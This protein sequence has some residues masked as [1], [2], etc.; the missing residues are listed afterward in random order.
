MNA[1]SPTRAG[2]DHDG[3]ARKRSD[4]AGVD[5]AGAPAHLRRGRTPQVIALASATDLLAP[6][7][8]TDA[9][10]VRAAIAAGSGAAAAGDG[11]AAQVAAPEWIELI[12]AGLFFGRDGRGPYRFDEPGAVIAATEALR[13][14]AGIPI[15]YDHATDFAAPEGRPA[16]AAGW[17]RELKVRSGALWGRVEWTD[18]AARAISEREYRYISPVFQYSRENGNVTRLLRAGLTNNPNLYLTAICAAGSE[19]DQDMDEFDQF[20]SE[21]KQLLDMSPGSSFGEII[22]AISNLL[23]TVAAARES[24]TAQN[25]AVAD[26]ARYVA[27]AEFKKAL[28][29]LNALKVERA[30]E[31]AEHA[32]EQ[33]IRS[34]RLVPAQREWAVSYCAADPEA[35]GSFVAR[36]PATTLSG[37]MLSSR[38][39]AAHVA[40]PAPGAALSQVEN[41]IC[42]QLG[43]PSEDFV[44]R[45]HGRSDFLKIN[46]NS[47]R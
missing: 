33:A 25:A 12:P 2:G 32:V 31:K 13:M 34:G 44:S 24:E 40:A 16:P 11:G 26:P 37:E 41:A 28:T 46:D 3:N 35:F 27:V 14:D 23:A 29:E 43:V 18:R 47:N 4:T 19:E 6:A 22:E 36:Q 15:D 39:G 9:A 42:A 21:L 7:P 45:K 38:P 8:R 5:T 10:L 20:L 17:I 1:L 30:R